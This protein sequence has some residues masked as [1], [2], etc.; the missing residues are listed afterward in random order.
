MIWLVLI[1]VYIGLNAL[2]ALL[3]SSRP[4]GARSKPELVLAVLAQGILIC[5]LIRLLIWFF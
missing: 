1:I 5:A 4:P 2:S 3:A